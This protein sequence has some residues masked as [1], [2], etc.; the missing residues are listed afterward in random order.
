[1]KTYQT[2]PLIFSLFF[3][4]TNNSFGQASVYGY[5]GCIGGPPFEGVIVTVGIYADTTDINGNY[6][7]DDIPAGYYTITFNIPGSPPT[8]Y[9]IDLPDGMATNADLELNCG[10]FAVD[11][12]SLNV[13]IEPNATETEILTLTNTGDAPVQWSAEIE[14]S[15]GNN[16]DD[17]FDLISQV[18]LQ[19]TAMEKGVAS[20]DEFIYT[21]DPFGFIRRYAFNGTF[22]EMLAVGGYDDLAWD[23]YYFY[24]CDGSTTITY[25]DLA[26]QYVVSTFTA[27]GNVSTITYNPIDNVFYGT[28]WNSDLMAFDAS[29]ALI[30]STPLPPENPVYTG[31]AFDNCSPDGPFLWAYGSVGAQTHVIHLYQVPSLQLASFTADMNEILG[32]PLNNGSGGLFVSTKVVDGICALGGIVQGEWLWAVELTETYQ[33]INIEP[34]SGTV[35]PGETEEVEVHFDATGLYPCPWPYEAEIQFSTIPNVASP[36]VGVELTLEAMCSPYNI[37]YAFDCLDLTITWDQTAC[38]QPPESWNIYL[39]DDIIANVTEQQTTLSVYPEVEY[40]F[41]VSAIFN[42]NIETW[43]VPG[44]NITIPAPEGLEPSG[45]SVTFPPADSIICFGWTTQA[46]IAPEYFKIYRD[47]TL[48]AE[49][50]DYSFCDTLFTPGYYE[51]YIN[52][53]YYFGDSDPCEPFYFLWVGTSISGAKEMRVQVF[54]NPAEDKITIN[55][56]VQVTS[57]SIYDYSGMVQLSQKFT[58]KIIDVSTLNPGCYFLVLETEN[59]RSFQKLVIK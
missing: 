44:D 11:P 5:V 28:S 33:W 32:G 26:A 7:I 50:P 31:L 56:T 49:T 53:H 58:H 54:P 45:I 1:M 57:I 17:F 27:P 43:P 51:Y 30:S 42:E 40:Q 59:G 34:V 23:G 52:A 37:Q 21:T 18:P 24:G 14:I 48:I 8:S 10:N 46:C 4:F 55:T 36:T 9:G 29:G 6:E 39:N 41:S 25:L 2:I 12:I 20:D 38:C 47:G 35:N 19:E 22:I 16:A 3:L 15:N 13:V